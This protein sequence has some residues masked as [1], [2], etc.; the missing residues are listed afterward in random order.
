LSLLAFANIHGH[1]VNKLMTYSNPR[2]AVTTLHGKTAALAP[3]LM[4]KGFLLDL[5]AA[6][7]DAL[8]TFSGDIE[9]Q[10]T[11]GEVVL[12][13]ARLGMKIS[14]LSLGLATEASFGP[15]PLLGFMAVHHEILAFIDDV[16]G[17]VLL[18]D[19]I[20]HDTNWQSK[21]VRSMDEA[22]PIMTSTGFPEHALLVRPNILTPGAPV[23]KGIRSRDD[24]SAAI[25]ELAPLSRDGLARVDTDMRAHMN[26]T[27][28]HKIALLAERLVQRLC[29]HCSAC[30]AP[31]FG[32]QSP[33]YGLPCADCGAPTGHIRAERDG[34]G[35][36]GHET[37]YLRS[38]YADPGAC[39]FCNP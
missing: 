15:D 1:K 21:T 7:T 32:A 35:V 4:P 38:G 17:Q 22:L 3:A 20:S 33:L 6:D 19:H 23:Y 9:R 14:G 18:L 8:G 24:L 2:I 26:P 37:L 29:T 11:P 13:K 36:C 12:A 31:G 27:R 10:G 34:C 16:H 25:D 5:V 30:T 28:M 39:P